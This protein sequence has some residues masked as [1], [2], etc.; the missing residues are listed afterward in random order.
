VHA[1]LVA[2]GLALFLGATISD[3]AYFRSYHIQWQNFASWLIVGGL[4]FSGFAMVF[5]IVDWFDAAR[6]AAGSV[7]YGILLFVT[8]LIALYNALVHGRD[9]WASMPASLI[10]SVVV[11]VLIVIATWLGFSRGGR[12]DAY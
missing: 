8:W 4:T 1:V 6:R 11:M 10:L 7:F 9:A 3:V 12:H 2:G 5:A